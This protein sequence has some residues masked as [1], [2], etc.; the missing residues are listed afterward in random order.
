VTISPESVARVEA[1]YRDGL[2]YAEIVAATGVSS[3]SVCRIVRAAGLTGQRKGGPRPARLLGI[4]VLP[5]CVGCGV[6]VVP[7]STR[8]GASDEQRSAWY[9]AG[10]T[11]VKSGGRCSP[12]AR[13]VERPDDGTQAAAD[14]LAALADL[15]HADDHAWTYHALCA[16]SDPEMWFPEPSDWRASRAAQRVCA[17]C[18]VRA[19]CLGAG[20]T[21]DHGVWGGTTPRERMTLRR[22]A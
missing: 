18:P 15:L 16:Q 3:G 7:Y 14:A 8:M 21:S 11:A 4:D 22:T 13:G 17:A 9:E 12:C 2:T 10:A 20:M 1:L 6:P 19:Q 5:E